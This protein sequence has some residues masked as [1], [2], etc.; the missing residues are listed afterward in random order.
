V[1]KATAFVLTHRSNADRGGYSASF[2]ALH[3]IRS[4][5]RRGIPVVRV[6]PGLRELSLYSRYCSSVEDSPNVHESEAALLEFLLDLA[7]KYEAPRV[8]LPAS[9]DTVHFLGRYREPLLGAYR[10]PAPSRAT[11]ETIIDKRNQ[12]AAAQA[13]GIPIPETHFPADLAEVEA[14]AGTLRGYPY[15][16][17]PNVAHHWRLASVKQRMRWSNGTTIKAVVVHDADELR[18]EYRQISEVDPAVMIQKVIGG[19]DERLYAFFGYF[20][21]RSQPLGYCVRRKFRQLPLRFGY[22]T[23]M[24]SCEDETV[25]QQTLRLL[26]GLHYHGIVAVE[27]KRDPESDDYKLIEINARAPNAIALATACGV[28]LPYIAFAD[29][30]GERV[31]R[32]TRARTGVKWLW[33][34][35]D[36]WAARQLMRRRELK[37]GEWLRSLRGKKA[38]PVYAADDILPFLVELGVLLKSQI[39]RAARRLLAAATA[40]R[41]LAWRPAMLRPKVAEVT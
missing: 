38:Y 12:Y 28:D 27:W 35:A 24:E 4:L 7:Q 3:M 16:I 37:L 33:F 36:L 14:L 32:L 13:L 29:A 5:G 8:L 25:V 17:K 23:L 34:V 2:Q 26:Q 15:I 30:I 11:I 10:I 6:H 19:G 41:K 22:A 40:R 31:P 39:A 1:K 18:K 9:D 20:D 21:E